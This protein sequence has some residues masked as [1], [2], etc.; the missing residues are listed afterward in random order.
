MRNERELRQSGS[1]VALDEVRDTSSFAALREEWDGLLESSGA[2]VFNSWAWLYPWSRRLAPSTQLRILTARDCDGR[3]VGVLPLHLE[4]VR[5]LGRKVRRLSFLG[6]RRVG[7]DY[8]DVIAARGCEVPVA[9]AMATA[10][11]DGSGG[12]DVMDL[13]DLHEGSTT[14]SLFREVFRDFNVRTRVRMT[15]PWERFEPGETFEA[16]LRRT[17]RRDNFLRRKKWLEKQPGYRLEVSTRPEALARP[18][19]EFF[20]LHALRWDLEGGSSGITGPEVEAF[21]RDATWALAES[22]KLRLYT[23]WIGEKAVASVYGIVHGDTFSYYQAGYDPEWRDKSVGLVLV[24]A[25]FE[26]AMGGGLR[27]YD[28]L[29][30]TETY[31][32]DWVSKTRSTIGVRVFASTGAGAWLDAVEQGARDVKGVLE[33][34]LPEG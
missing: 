30:G 1:W 14:P 6:E 12:W 16:F 4:T 25:T 32:S 34:V 19:A 8:L 28:F 33:R 31:K 13:L 29:R 18:L 10:L 20:R 24:G 9:R 7:S 2:G 22:G 3:L 23:M 26:D 27:E 11:R 17:R 15:C 21:H 5:V